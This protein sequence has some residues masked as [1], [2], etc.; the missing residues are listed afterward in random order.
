MRRLTMRCAVNGDADRG[1]TAILVVIFATVMLAFGALAVDMGAGWWEK[2]QLQSGADSAALS[3]AQA[4][5]KS[6]TTG[7]CTT[8]T[9]VAQGIANASANDGVSKLD[10]LGLNT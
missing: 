5:A 6:T 8:A 2:S 1:A 7:P 9:T 3:V 4:C 10:S